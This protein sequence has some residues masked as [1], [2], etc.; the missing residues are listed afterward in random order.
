M[1]WWWV[2]ETDTAAA[3]CEVLA[4]LVD[5]PA[6]VCFDS[7]EQALV[8]PLAQVPPLVVARLELPCTSGIHLVRMLRRRTPRPRVLVVSASDHPIYAI[9]A[10][11]AGA[12]GFQRLELGSGA[13]AM[14][15]LQ[16]ADGRVAVDRATVAAITASSSDELGQ[17]LGR[18]TPREFEVLQMALRGRPVESIAAGLCLRPSTVERHLASLRR[19]IQVD[20]EAGLA[21][22]SKCLSVRSKYPLCRNSRDMA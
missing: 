5:W 21:A 7:A 17:R 10:R 19:R 13:L 1:R 12:R 15:V 2:G 11:K 20:D 3:V 6:P 16:V 14:A 9:R 4:G 22:L 8:A 18:L